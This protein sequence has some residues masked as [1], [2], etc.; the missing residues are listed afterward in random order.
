MRAQMVGG[1]APHQS[2]GFAGLFGCAGFVLTYVAFRY[3][4]AGIIAPTH[5]SQIIWGVLAGMFIFSNVPDGWTLL[6]CA[7]I[8]LSGIGLAI[9]GRKTQENEFFAL[10]AVQ[11]VVLSI[12]HVRLRLLRSR[13]RIRKT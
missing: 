11:S 13:S 6:G 7:I 10:H 9:L 5:Y 1:E 12:Q 3:A 2:C 4:P 8:I